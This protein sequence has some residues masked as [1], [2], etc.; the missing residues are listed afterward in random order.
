MG[1]YYE[2]LSL[3]ERVY[4]Q[5]QLELGFKAAAIAT[6]LKRNPPTV[7]CELWRNRRAGPARSHAKAQARE[8]GQLPELSLQPSASVHETQTQA[9][10]IGPICHV[11]FAR[12]KLR[13]LAPIAE[14]KV[15]T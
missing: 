9:L 2:Q 13:P 12:R 8:L 1:K 10:N 3:S 11:N 7:S 5:A 14:S 6:V 15:S 4:I